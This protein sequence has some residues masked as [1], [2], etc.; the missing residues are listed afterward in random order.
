M[1]N[2]NNKLLLICEHASNDLKGTPTDYKEK[3]YLL[4]HDAFDPGAADLSNYISEKTKCLALHT[5]FSK[6]L[7]NP[8][9]PLI[10]DNLVQLKYSDGSFISFN[11]DGYD[12]AE[13]LDNF[14]FIYHKIL[15]EILWFLNP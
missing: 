13:R 3:S 10:A 7:V 1:T 12:L 6:L 15:A 11:K 8:S 2:S 4:G 5:N 14:Y 9:L